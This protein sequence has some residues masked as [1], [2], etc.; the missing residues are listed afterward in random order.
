[1]DKHCSLKVNQFRIYEAYKLFLFQNKCQVY[2]LNVN[3]RN[4]RTRTRTLEQY[5]KSNQNIYSKSTK[6]TPEL[7]VESVQIKNENTETTSRTL[8]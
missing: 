6:E 4:P 3:K 8:F 5:L 1:M 2:L 7:G